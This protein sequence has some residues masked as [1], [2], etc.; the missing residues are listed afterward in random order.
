MH[1]QAVSPT[2][3]HDAIEPLISDIEEIAEEGGVVV[4]S[5]GVPRR[6]TWFTVGGEVRRH[7]LHAADRRAQKM[8]TASLCSVGVAGALRRGRAANL[9]MRIQE[10]VAQSFR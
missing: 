10:R 7:I 5:D 4:I 8:C 9:A 2:L 1:S 6:L 3:V